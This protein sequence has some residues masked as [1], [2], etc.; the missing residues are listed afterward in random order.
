M[1]YTFAALVLCLSFTLSSTAYADDNFAGPV[2]IG[3]SAITVV[4]G[5]NATSTF[6]NG[7]NLPIGGCFSIAGLCVNQF[8]RLTPSEDV[9]IGEQALEAF[10]SGRFNSAIGVK[11]LKQMTYGEY[12][13]AFGQAAGY[14][15][16]SGFGNSFLGQFTGIATNDGT[17][18]GDHNVFVGNGSGDNIEEGAT[19]NAN[20]FIGTFT[21]NYQTLQDGASYNILLGADT[22]LANTTDSYQLNIQNIIYGTN[23]SGTQY[24]ISPGNIGIGTTTPLG[25]FSIQGDVAGTAPYFVIAASDNSTEYSVNSVGHHIYG[26]TLPTISACGTGTTNKGNDNRGRVIVG[27][28]TVTSCVLTFA[29]AWDKAPVCSVTK[30]TGALVTMAANSTKTAV[31][32]KSSASLAGDTFNY[33][34]DGF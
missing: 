12:N 3:T 1:K 32:F 18:S 7:I 15:F 31:T 9:A 13:N 30:E 27:T 23:N 28:G 33:A 26:G 22:N 8:F 14:S 16:A 21:A 20:T 29:N 25:R 6:T 4:S 10:S 2:N 11:S 34:C 5:D 19:L 24:N 17:W